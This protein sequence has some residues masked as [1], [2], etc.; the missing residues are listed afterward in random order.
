MRNLKTVESRVLAV[1]KGRPAARFD[2]M[3]LYLL[4]Y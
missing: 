1:L 4:Q 2:D 3:L